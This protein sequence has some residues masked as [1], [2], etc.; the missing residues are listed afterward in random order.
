MPARTVPEGAEVLALV[1]LLLTIIQLYFCYMIVEKSGLSGWWA[2][3][4]VVPVLSL[5][6]VWVFAF[7]EWPNVPKRSESDPYRQG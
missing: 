3:T 2:L 1:L 7:V 5:V 6:F 4:Q